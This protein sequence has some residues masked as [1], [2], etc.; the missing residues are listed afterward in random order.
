MQAKGNPLRAA[1]NMGRDILNF[2]AFVLAGNPPLLSVLVTSA[3]L[4]F[5]LD[6][7]PARSALTTLRLE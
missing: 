2:A 3:V 4:G 6:R 1:W 5:L 7:L